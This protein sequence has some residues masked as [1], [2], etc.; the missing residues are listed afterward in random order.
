M[1][2]EREKKPNTRGLILYAKRLVEYFNHDYNVILLCF[3]RKITL[4]IM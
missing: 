4:L 2:W 3:L 1:K